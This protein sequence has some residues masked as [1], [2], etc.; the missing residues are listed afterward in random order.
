MVSVSR[1]SS[2]AIIRTPDRSS[3]RQPPQRSVAQRSRQRSFRAWARQEKITYSAGLLST[4]RLC[5]TQGQSG[6]RSSQRWQRQRPQPLRRAAS[7][8]AVCAAIEVTCAP[9]A[10]CPPPPQQTDQRHQRNCSRP[11]SKPASFSNALPFPAWVT[12]IAGETREARQRAAPPTRL[13]APGQF[14]TFVR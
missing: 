12:A 10:T 5:E 9:P 1:R 7:G 3:L 8:E 4:V 14:R 13:A 6:P 2:H 11:S